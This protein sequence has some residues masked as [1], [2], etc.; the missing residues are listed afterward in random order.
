MRKHNTIYPYVVI[1][2]QKYRSLISL[3]GMLAGLI[4]LLTLAIRIFEQ[5]S[6]RIIHIILLVVSIGLFAQQYNRYQKRKKN[7]FRYLFLLAGI[8]M[9]VIPP[10][11]PLCFL[12]FILAILEKP[13]TTAEEIGFSDELIVFSG[14]F[15]RKIYWHELTNVILKDGILTIDFRNNNLIQ[16]ETDDVEEEETYDVSEEEFNEYCRE[17]L[18]RQPA[19]HKD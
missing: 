10:F 14:F 12:Y 4:F 13:A 7:S 8:T 1:I 5:E 6:S 15:K 17:I 19:S 2:K 3:I 11:Q 9:M 16:K 18:S